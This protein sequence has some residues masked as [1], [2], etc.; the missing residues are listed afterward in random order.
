M[1]RT[2]Q[3]A[4]NV[5]VKQ[6]ETI[7]IVPTDALVQP[8]LGLVLTPQTVLVRVHSRLPPYLDIDAAARTI[9]PFA[10]SSVALLTGWEAHPRHDTE[11][12]LP[13]AACCRFIATKCDAG[14]ALIHAARGGPNSRHVGGAAE[15]A[16]GHGQRQCLYGVLT[17]T[18]PCA[19]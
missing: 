17:S 6:R 12:R 4:I 1:A 8:P 14:R 11:A 18:G 19:A 7:S 15:G 2:Y 13:L 9:A 10:C 3:R 5:A 16:P